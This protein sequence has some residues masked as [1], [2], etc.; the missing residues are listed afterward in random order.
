MANERLVAD[1]LPPIV[2][3]TQLVAA[4][5]QIQVI[6]NGIGFDEQYVDRIFQ[7]FQRLHGE[8]EYAGTGI[9]MAICEKVVANHGGGVMARSQPGQGATFTIYLLA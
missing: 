4:Y 7:V 2:K 3:P 9:G 6:D 1:A 8:G 5:H